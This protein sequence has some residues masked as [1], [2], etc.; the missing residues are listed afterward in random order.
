MAWALLG[1]AWGTWVG[2]RGIYRIL[3]HMNHDTAAP[4]FVWGM[5]GVLALVGLVVGAA[6]AVAVGL[7]ARGLLQG[8]R[9][10]KA[11]AT[12]VALL[13]VVLILGLATQVVGRMYPGLRP[14]QAEPRPPARIATP[15]SS[16]RA[17]GNPCA[18]PPPGDAR[19][20]AS[21]DLECR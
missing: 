17:I 2:F 3:P 18:A 15:G 11:L 10:G 19:E 6:L 20:R 4:V 12:A 21:W 9:T 5:Y 16:E 14:L 8:L 7:G 13:A 1:G